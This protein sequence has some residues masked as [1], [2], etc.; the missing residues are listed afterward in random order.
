M[1]IALELGKIGHKPQHAAVVSKSIVRQTPYGQHQ[2]EDCYVIPSPPAE[3]PA[4]YTTF[5]GTEKV[6]EHMKSCADI[7]TTINIS[8]LVRRLDDALN[9]W[10]RRI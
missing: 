8:A 7:F 3:D 10:V 9:R 4:A 2:G 5:V 6:R 1:L